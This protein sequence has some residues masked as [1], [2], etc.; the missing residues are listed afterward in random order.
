MCISRSLGFVAGPAWSPW[1]AH[2]P[3]TVSR[4]GPRP[5][6]PGDGTTPG[7][8]LQVAEMLVGAVLA[9]RMTN[10]R[11]LQSGETEFAQDV[12][13]ELISRIFC[14]AKPPP[15]DPMTTAAL[16][17]LPWFGDRRQTF[18]AR[19]RRSVYTIEFSALR[20]IRQGHSSRFPYP[21]LTRSCQ[22]A[23]GSCCRRHRLSEF[24]PRVR[25]LVRRFRPNGHHH[26]PTLRP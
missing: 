20:A 17:S 21:P 14:L 16:Y 23:G 8:L 1:S 9:E 11:S 19:S 10:G 26:S 5:I 22:P 13:R 24:A 6:G 4:R 18:P 2:L 12:L 15:G 25:S 7:A 3:A